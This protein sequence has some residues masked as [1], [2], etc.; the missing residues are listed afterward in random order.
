[1]LGIAYQ[2]QGHYQ[3]AR[4]AYEQALQILQGD[5]QSL[6]QYANA[7]ESFASLNSITSSPEAATKLWAKALNIHKQLGNHRALA[8]D[9]SLFAAIQIGEKH[10]RPAKKALAQAVDEAKS[11]NGLS[12][13]DSVFL[14]DT[15]AWLAKIQGDK[16]SELAA[17]LHSLEIRKHGSGDLPL[18]GWAYLYVGGAYADRKEWEQALTNV[19]AGLEIL[20]RTVGHENPQYITGQALYAKV[21]EKNGMHDEASRLKKQVERRMN[22]LYSA[23]C[24]GCTLS[25]AGFH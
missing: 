23:Q 11:T 20:A 14:S 16:Q 22:D 24:V 8:R 2:G 19:R 1:L 10:I 3:Q 17:Y 25:A 21:L 7:L 9:Y 5:A 15:Q 12:D 18:T 13:E 4:N 6:A